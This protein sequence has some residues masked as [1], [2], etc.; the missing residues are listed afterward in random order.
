MLIKKRPDFFGEG[1]K[2]LTQNTYARI[3]KASLFGVDIRNGWSSS[4][5][6]AGL[7]RDS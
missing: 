7:L 4:V 2:T 1:G 5:S 6:K 3:D